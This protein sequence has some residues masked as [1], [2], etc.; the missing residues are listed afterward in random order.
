MDGGSFIRPEYG[1]RCFSEIPQLVK[2]MLTGGERPG[3]PAEVFDGLEERYEAVVLFF[4]DAFGWRF[5]ERFR[6]RYSFLNPPRGRGSVVQLTAQFPSTTAAHVTCVH[7]G[8]PVGQSGVLEWNYYEPRLDAIIVPLLFSYAGEKKRGTLGVEAGEILP[9]RTIYRELGRKGV[10]SHAFQPWEH[11]ASPYAKLTFG[12]AEVSPYATLAEALVNLGNLVEA[13]RGPAY[14]FFYFDGID[15]VGH[16]YGPVSAQVEAEIDLFLT[17]LERLFFERLQGKVSKSK[18]LCALTADHGLVEVDPR[19]TVYLNRER[20]LAGVERF[21]RRNRR[22]ELLV[23]GGS[24]RDMFLYVREGLVEEACGFLAERLA[25][26]A[27]VRR[28][29]QLAE[30]GYFGPEPLVPE[31]W[32]RAGDLVIL[33]FANASVWWYEKGKFEMKKWGYHGGLTRAEME[34]PLVLWE[35]G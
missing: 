28:V 26:V 33:P 9:G 7:T 19:R 10:P 24:C 21:L 2:Y 35:M 11:L 17:A 22:G 32:E 8:L 20:R 5:F 14:F 13:R 3:L 4:V 23:P 6:E 29:R 18:V 34:I 15:A 16:E 27:E 1:V 31:F 12:G 30:D 25:G